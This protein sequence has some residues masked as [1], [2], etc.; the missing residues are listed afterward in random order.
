MPK[1]IINA[2]FATSVHPLRRLG[3]IAAKWSTHLV[4]DTAASKTKRAS[5]E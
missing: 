2:G 4:V 1:A 3:Q 5:G